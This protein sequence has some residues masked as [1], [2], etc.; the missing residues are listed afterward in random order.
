MLLRI[1]MHRQRAVYHFTGILPL[2]ILPRPEILEMCFHLV[3]LTTYENRLKPA[4]VSG[5]DFQAYIALW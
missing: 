3:F 4:L 5:G 1:Q 2:S